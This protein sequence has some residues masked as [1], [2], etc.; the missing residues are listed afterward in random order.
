MNRPEW[1]LYT[2]I[3]L[4]RVGSFYLGQRGKGV[5]SFQSSGIYLCNNNIL[6]IFATLASKLL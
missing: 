2:L 1:E 3:G 6:I 5:C 4:L